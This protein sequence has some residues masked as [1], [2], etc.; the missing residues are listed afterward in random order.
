MLQSA[1]VM[2]HISCSSLPLL[3][4]RWLAASYFIFDNWHLTF[5]ALK[6]TCQRDIDTKQ[7]ISY[8]YLYLYLCFGNIVFVCLKTQPVS[9]VKLCQRNIDTK[10][11]ISYPANDDDW[12]VFCICICMFENIAFVCLKTQRTGA[13][14]KDVLPGFV[15]PIPCLLLLCADFPFRFVTFCFSVSGIFPQF[16]WFWFQVPFPTKNQSRLPASQCCFSFP[17]PASSLWNVDGLWMCDQISQE[18]FRYLKS[19]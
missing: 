8:L 12:K 1:Y 15:S 17:V 5:F 6:F 18:G 7:H 2:L 16:I 4:S 10:Q 11:H 13:T 14:D 19:W 3:R 9:H